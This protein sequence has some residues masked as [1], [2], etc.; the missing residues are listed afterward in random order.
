M[1]YT[2]FL[3]SLLLSMILASASVF[4]QTDQP[5]EENTSCNAYVEGTQTAH[6]SVYIPIVVTIGAAILF[7]IADQGSH[8]CSSGDSQDALGSIRDSKRKG[9]MSENVNNHSR[10]IVRTVAGYSH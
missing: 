10:K 5:I 3:N 1:R 8:K 6:W 7:G 9:I 4:G 2:R